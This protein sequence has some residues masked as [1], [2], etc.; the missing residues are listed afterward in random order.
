MGE[1]WW[2]VRPFGFER[3]PIL[4]DNGDQVVNKNGTRLW[5][6]KHNPVEA[7]AIKDAYTAVL[8]EVPLYKITEDWNAAGLTTPRGNTWRGSQVRQL[9]LSPR[10]AGFRS[11]RGELQTDEDG[12]PLKGNWEE[13]VPEETWRHVVDKLADPKRRTGRSRGRKHL[14]SNIA[15]CGECGSGMGSGVT[16]RPRQNPIYTCKSCNRVSRNAAY[17]DELAITAVVERLSRDDA[18]NLVRPQER[19]G[20]G[21]ILEQQRALRARLDSLATDFA[22]GVLSAAQIKT[23][24]KRIN[25]KLKQVNGVI[26]DTQLTHIFDGLIDVDVPTAFGALSLDRKRAVIDA[27]LEITVKPSGRC[28]RTFRRED[29]EISF[30]TETGKS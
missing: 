3:E 24:T 2:S 25:E 9:L 21:E 7:K 28:G 30:K 6:P 5:K 26:F 1:Q 18:I 14:L 8:G 19:D 20:L 23:A 29:V 17:V 12:Q 10:N 16:K 22:D 27:L 13:I 4:N 11:F 15:K